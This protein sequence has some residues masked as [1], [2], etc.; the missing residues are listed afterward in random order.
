MGCGFG[1]G[2]WPKLSSSNGITWGP[3]FLCT[4]GD[5]VCIVGFAIGGLVCTLGSGVVFVPTTFWIGDPTT[6]GGCTSSL[7]CVTF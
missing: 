1:G 6:L 3:L 4:L 7:L 2:R 5:G